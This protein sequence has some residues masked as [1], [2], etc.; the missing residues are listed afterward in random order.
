MRTSGDDTGGDCGDGALCA[1]ALCVRRRLAS[2]ERPLSLHYTVPVANSDAVPY[3]DRQY[4]PQTL[5]RVTF[6]FISSNVG[7]NMLALY[8][9][10]ERVQFGV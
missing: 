5:Y 8:P 3:S 7:F 4:P 9:K 6:S 10:L 1:S 2:G